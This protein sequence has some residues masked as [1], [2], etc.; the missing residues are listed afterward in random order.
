MPQTVRIATIADVAPG[1]AKVIDADGRSIALFNVD[2]SF[3]A[4]DNTCPH[5]G[6]A[7]GEGTV[8]G[9]TVTCPWHGAE[10]NIKTGEVQ[11]P[12][13]ASGVRSYPVSVEGDDIFIEFD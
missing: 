2:G 11:S 6:G 7:L 4:L 9:D 10:F 8:V 5:M 3:F 12:P 1:S 13:A